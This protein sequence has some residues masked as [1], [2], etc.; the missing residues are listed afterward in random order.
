MSIT[1]VTTSYIEEK[2]QLY[3]ITHKTPGK[4][5]ERLKKLI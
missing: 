5:R 3:T 1:N 2:V 4:R